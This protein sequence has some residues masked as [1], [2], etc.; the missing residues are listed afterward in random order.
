[1]GLQTDV[2][3]RPRVSRGP[4]DSG[5]LIIRFTLETAAI[6]W[7]ARIAMLEFVFPRRF[8]IVWTEFRGLRNAPRTQHRVMTEDDFDAV[9]GV[10]STRF[11]LVVPRDQ[12]APALAVL[13]H[14]LEE[15]DDMTD[16]RPSGQRWSV[17]SAQSAAA[18]TT[19]VNWVPIVLTL[20]AG[21]AAF[22]GVR[23]VNEHIEAGPPRGLRG[24][25]SDLWAEIGGSNTPWV[26]QTVNQRGTRELWID[27]QSGT[28]ILR[29]DADGDGEFERRQVFAQSNQGH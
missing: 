23:R 5:I 21:S 28:A 6:A 7:S 20:A 1:M 10:W 15:P 8:F 13:R 19:G 4:S 27:A 18:E 11:L 12:A 16:S 24:Q 22:L 25:P 3:G 9:G 29:E 14:Q 26:Q 2:C 17:A